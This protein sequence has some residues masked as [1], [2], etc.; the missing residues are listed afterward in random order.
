MLL[1][2]EWYVTAQTPP[3]PA[4]AWAFAP[5]AVPATP[6]PVGETFG[7]YKILS[8]IQRGGMGELFLAETVKP[9]GRRMKVVLKRLLAD[10]VN[11]AQHVSMFRSEAKLMSSLDHPNIVKVID[12]PKIEGKQCLALEYV[13]GRNVAQIL[14]QCDTLGIKMPPQIALYIL[15]EVLKGLHHAH[16]F[17]LRDGR[18]LD[19]VHRDVTPSNILVSFDG[20]V[21]ITDFG[22]AK[23]EM[24]S[25]STTVGVVKGTTRYL[26]PEQIRGRDV[27]ARTDIFSAAV[28]LVEL[29]TGRSLFDRGSVPPTMLAIV[30]GER[31]P[32]SRL[33]PFNAPRLAVA[34]EQALMVHPQA[35]QD[36]AEAFL[37]ELMSA[38]AQLGRP[39]ELRRHQRLLEAALSREQGAQRL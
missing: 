17:V 30:S 27:S 28:V 1:G 39:G 10:L 35:R 26:S 5:T 6:L 23:S 15:C 16:T 12:I 3:Y 32:I 19:A 37:H 38:A 7:S 13:Q 22:I 34:L 11:D 24:S 4:H 9:S 2:K 33:L 21:K 18:P 14:K 31:P 36:S 20:E 25:V 8:T 29:L